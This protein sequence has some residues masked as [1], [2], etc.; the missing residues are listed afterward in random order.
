M[1]LGSHRT[2]F[3]RGLAASP[4]AQAYRQ[5]R[6]L[7]R[8]HDTTKSA[9]TPRPAASTALTI[10][11]QIPYIAECGSFPSRQFNVNAQPYVTFVS[12]FRNDSYTN[13]F[14]LRVKRATRFLVGQLQRA[15][16]N[17]KVSPRR[18]ESATG[19]SP[20]SSSRWTPCR[21]AATCSVRAVVVGKEHHQ[22][23][24]RLAGMGH[25]PAAAANVGARRPKAVS[26]RQRP[27][28]PTCRTNHS[29]NAVATFTRMP[30]IVVATV[31]MSAVRSRSRRGRRPRCLRVSRASTARGTP[32]HIHPNG[33]YA[34]CIRMPAATFS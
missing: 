17:P 19:P 31:A 22:T 24:P 10:R 9:R 1:H 33:T 3:D 27:P 20:S 23:F 13:D 5:R 29:H 2:P 28:I 21:K 15:E 25:E 34:T 32:C 8:P 7:H 4:Q 11:C 30:S 12:Y 16:P 26:S 6:Y 14:V 18:M